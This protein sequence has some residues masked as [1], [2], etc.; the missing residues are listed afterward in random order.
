MG[1]MI[2]A[3]GLLITFV[4]IIVHFSEGS[5]WFKH[6][7]KLPGDIRIEKENFNFYMPITTMLII[8]A[9]LHLIMRIFHWFN[10]Q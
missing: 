4:G 10:K 3:I 5:Q 2:I 8:S 9:I 6:I 7:G 1:K